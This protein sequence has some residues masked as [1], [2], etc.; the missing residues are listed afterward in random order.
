VFFFFVK[1]HETLNTEQSNIKTSSNT[2]KQ[3][4]MPPSETNGNSKQTKGKNATAET[5]IREKSAL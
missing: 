5:A 4:K 2:A 3:I 1:N